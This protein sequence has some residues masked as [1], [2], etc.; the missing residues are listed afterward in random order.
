MTY[1][2]LASRITTWAAAQSDIIA[3]V[4]VGSKARGDADLW[5]DLDLLLFTEDLTR[6]LDA[7]WLHTLG[8]VWLTYKD[9]AGPGDPEW[10]VIYEGG[11]KVDI[12]L[13]QVDEPAATLEDLLQRYPYQTVFARGVKVLFDRHGQARSLP[14]RPVI[15]PPPSASEFEHVVNGFLLESVTTAKFIAR[16]DF[17]RAQHWLAHDLRPNLLKLIA[18][19][20][21]GRDTWYNGRFIDVWADPRVLTSLPHTFAL[22]ERDSLYRALHTLL[23]LCRLVGEETADHF[24]FT[25]P[26]E[27]HLK[28]TH[29]IK[30]ILE[31]D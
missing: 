11:L 17:L 28:I 26:T 4:A 12:V 18:W 16:G 20:A 10:F 13:L 21:N 31:S 29:L 1:E 25:Y 9:E 23:D 27:T 5:S 19:H 14:T 24:T 6:Y 30:T 2:L 22:Y 7:G 8:D 15:A 3:V